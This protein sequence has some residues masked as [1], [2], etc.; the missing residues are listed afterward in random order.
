MIS[1]NDLKQ[2]FRGI[3]KEVNDS[4]LRYWVRIRDI[5][6]DGVVSLPEYVAG[7]VHQLDPVIDEK[8]ITSDVSPLTAAVGALRLGSSTA[9]C[10]EAIR[11][12]EEYIQRILDSP[13]N[14]SYWRIAR[15]DKAYNSKIGR[16]FG[17]DKVL[18]G[19]I[20]C[21]SSFDFMLPCSFWVFLR[22]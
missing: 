11:S 13:S 10:L 21:P 8:I 14:P 22:R 6:Q 16:L 12:V 1:V 20:E 3:G 17:G 7:F 5:D 4:Q 18:M 2:Y 9:E 19:R 15:D